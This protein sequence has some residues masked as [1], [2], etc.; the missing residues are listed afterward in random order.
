MPRPRFRPT[1]R[2]LEARETPALT[3]LY[4]GASLTL[5]GTPTAGPAERLLIQHVGSHDY[6]VTDGTADIGTYHVTRDLRLR[7]TSFDTNVALDL[8]GDALGGGVL[9]DVGAGDADRSTPAAVV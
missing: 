6:R 8:A 7:L 9:I 5:T 3:A 2:P 1:L 4:D